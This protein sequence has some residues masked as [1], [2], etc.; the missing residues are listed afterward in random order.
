MTIRAIILGTALGLFVACVGYFNDQV[1][2]QTFL[3]GNLFPIGVFGLLMLL[4]L[5]SGPAAAVLGGRGFSL[6]ASEWGVVV[7]MGLAVCGWPG[8][9][10]F[11]YFTMNLTMPSNWLKTKSAWQAAEVMAYVPGGSATLGEGHLRDLPGLAGL[12]A[13]EGAAEPQAASAASVVDA[14]VGPEGALGREAVVDRLRGALPAEA[15]AAAGRMV[16]EGRAS[17]NDARVLRTG[18]NEAIVGGR[19]LPA[20]LLGSSENF[21][22]EARDYAEERLSLLERWSLEAETIREIEGEYAGDRSAAMSD[23]TAERLA[24]ARE[25]L[26]FYEREARARAEHV[27][28]AV[29]VQALPGH[30]L[31]APR[32]EGVLLLGGRSDPAVVERVLQPSAARD[33][34]MPWDLWW[35]AWWPSILLWGG[36]ALLIGIASLCVVLVVHPQWSRREL[37]TYPIARFVEE[38]T[39]R[40]EGSL[41]PA[42]MHSRLF[43]YGFVA[44]AGLHLI[45]G[46]KAWNP[47]WIE[48]STTLPLGPLSELFPNVKRAP[49]TYGLWNPKIF[50]SVVAFTFFLTTEVSLSLGISLIV[51]AAVGG[52]LVANAIP[53]R[54]DWAGAD[55]YNMLMAGAFIGV[56]LVVLYIGRRHYWDVA[57]ASIG[58][59]RG[60]ETPSY[61]VWAMRVLV[62]CV[63]GAVALLSQQGLDWVLGLPLVLL[64]LM[65]FLVIA[66]VNAETG[67]FFIQTGFMPMAVVV[68]LFGID[69]IGPTAYLL[70]AVA[71]FMIVSDP[72]EAIMAHLANGMQIGD[73]PGRVSP[74][75]LGPIIGVMVVVGFAAALVTVLTLQHNFGANQRDTWARNSVATMPLDRMS[76]HISDL[77]STGTL[78]ASMQVRGLDRLRAISADPNNLGWLGLGAGLV[79]ATA[80]ARLRLPW[81]PIHP[82]LFVFW[83]TYPCAQ[84]WFS[85]LL[86]WLIKAAVVK[87]SGAKGY[88][89][90]KPMMIGVIG[91][92]LTAGML[93][94]LWGAA[95]Y[96]WTGLQPKSYFM[97]P[98]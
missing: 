43:W 47:G 93:W 65:I 61:S 94:L 41:L 28:R 4:V 22:G 86:G 1:I 23:A 83:G 67:A 5:V 59:R 39:E 15:R 14:A 21:S 68:A 52:F 33:L 37:L 32:G 82:V 2:R 11:R 50:L 19:L 20:E 98:G 42:V 71:S 70:M 95:Y 60:A 66:R 24:T 38:V 74:G 30:F 73:R 80:V 53:L 92:E 12:L 56:C 85:F 91:G 88:H 10:Y 69:A 40:R 31:S 6:R 58:F 75:R 77:S 51:W 87:V 57:R 64:F 48:I 81:W 49:G 17:A 96:F 3:V 13:G 35:D 8:S 7:A 9:G 97:F 76:A 79:L 27:T 29:L 44:V 84:F 45:N 90:V 26:G 16:R 46:L 78:E 36:L 55:N 63:L 25:R 34:T 72:R 54:S 18:I 62:L 89:A